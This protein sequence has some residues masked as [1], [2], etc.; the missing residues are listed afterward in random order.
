MHAARIERSARLQRVLRLLADGRW[1]STLD[2][3]NGA[4]V[5]AVNSCI[6]E[7]R[8]NGYAVACRRVGQERFEY[9]LEGGDGVDPQRAD[10]A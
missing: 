1:H 9:R 8:A 4:G 2:I 3:V 7:L 6:A 5:C 10:V